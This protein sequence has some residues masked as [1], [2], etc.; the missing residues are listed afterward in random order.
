MA[1]YN[2]ARKTL[3]PGL[4]SADILTKIIGTN[5]PN[6]V[7]HATFEGFKSLLSKDEVVRLRGKMPGVVPAAR[8]Q[9]AAKS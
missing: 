3:K 7:L 2:D 8:G 9:E 4:C 5:N 1:G 6:N